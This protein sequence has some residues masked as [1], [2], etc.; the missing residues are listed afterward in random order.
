MGPARVSLRRQT[1]NQPLANACARVR[2]CASA[3]G[4]RRRVLIVAR[5]HKGCVS[6]IFILP[7]TVTLAVGLRFFT[8]A[9]TWKL[10]ASSKVPA[11]VTSC[12]IN[13][14]VQSG[15]VV[16]VS[17]F[18]RFVSFLFCI[19]RFGTTGLQIINS[20]V[21]RARFAR[22]TCRAACVLRIRETDTLENDIREKD[23]ETQEEIEREKRSARIAMS[24]PSTCSPGRHSFV[25][26][27]GNE[28]AV[29]IAH[30]GALIA[31]VQSGR[32]K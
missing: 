11:Q 26:S 17:K 1:H 22:G 31:N 5:L 28:T 18:R 8:V 9:I 21:I 7:K 20:L 4:F 29:P 12:D 6:T 27:A 10:F 30:R 13:R 19:T 14:S 24:V 16:R 15:L 23:R 25:S 32:R 2:S 3:R